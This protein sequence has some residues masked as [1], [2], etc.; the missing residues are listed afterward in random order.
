MELTPRNYRKIPY[1]KK[2]LLFGVFA[3][4]LKEIAAGNIFKSIV[5][6]SFQFLL[7]LIDYLKNKRFLI[8]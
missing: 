2:Y 5:F 4:T 8:K 1:L 6:V 7:L 3:A